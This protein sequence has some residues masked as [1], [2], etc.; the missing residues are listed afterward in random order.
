M[1]IETTKAGRYYCQP[2]STQAGVL[3]S[4][5]QIAILSQALYFHNDVSCEGLSLSTEQSQCILWE[6]PINES[7][8][9]TTPSVQEVTTEDTTRPHSTETTNIKMPLKIPP[10]SNTDH[11]TVG[12]TVV[13]MTGT[14]LFLIV[15]VVCVV[16]CF[17]WR[18]RTNRSRVPHSQGNATPIAT[19]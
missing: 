10:T 16:Q 13:M 9:T 12:I 14:I 15:I 5:S 18:R 7:E 11:G 1:Q 8:Q 17:H 19:G 6:S 4:S 2:N 3:Q